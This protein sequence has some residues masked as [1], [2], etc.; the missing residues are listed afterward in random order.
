MNKDLKTLATFGIFWNGTSQ[1]LTQIFQLIVVVILARL[2][3]PRDF[4]IAGLATIFVG[5]VATI[6]E[7]GLSAAI[8]QRKNVDNVHL[9]TSFWINVI[10][11]IVLF[12][13]A[14]L[15]SPIVANF[16]KEDIIKPIVIVSSISL[17]IGSFSIIQ[18]ALLEKNLDFKKIT[19]VEICT[20]I[21]SGTISII[22]AIGGYGVWS[23]VV[24]G[25]S[26]SIISGIMLWNVNKW[27]PSLTFS[28]SHFKEL[29]DYGSNVMGS[30]FLGSVVMRIDS[31]IVGKIF[32]TTTLGYY[33]LAR[34]L[35]SFP[36]QRISWTI[37]RVI[38]PAFSI[39]Q[40]DSDTLRKGYLK[41]IRY[42]SL[43][44]FPMFA[45][46][47]VVAPEFISVFY[48]EK[49]SPMVIL[50]QILCIE[51]ALVSIG[52]LTNTM[53]NSKGR[54]DLPFKWHLY[55]VVIIPISII[56]GSKYGIVGVAIA[57]TIIQAIF[58]AIF[59]VIT[60]RLIDLKM[61]TYIKEL[62]P[63]MISSIVLIFG[64]KVYDI[65]ANDAE[66][67]MLLTSVVIGIIIYLLI[68][69][70]FYNHI[71]DETKKLLHDIRR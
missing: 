35:T 10:M 40:E 11:G 69:K 14:I 9:S 36:V 56:I 43:I 50:L 68:I 52:T 18:K 49:W 66:Y 3:S 16:F 57:L 42:V 61:S 33:T 22:M 6:N 17:I 37:M 4:G 67:N 70:I 41:V 46:M 47:L 60:N 45:G 55:A 30:K 32:G 54:S 65:F 7:L 48:G 34:N 8:I 15:L 71:L 64:I 19:I 12:I 63:A 27:R 21:I 62:T 24:G 51:A 23:I 20:T 26:G 59:Q 2:L 31:I 25:I 1:L 53:L 13:L 29:F 38:F 5:L 39:I 58:V 44:T 28:F